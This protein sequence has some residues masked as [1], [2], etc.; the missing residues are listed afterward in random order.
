MF[1]ASSKYPENCFLFISTWRL[2][3]LCIRQI[4][5]PSFKKFIKIIKSSTYF[6][7]IK[8]V[9]TS[10]SRKARWVVY[11]IICTAHGIILPWR[12]MTSLIAW[13]LE[14]RGI[15]GLRTETKWNNKVFRTS[16]VLKL[17]WNKSKNRFFFNISIQYLV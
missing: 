3:G 17:Q 15:V 6:C 1:R 12:T 13:I 8:L 14:F 5:K 7:A 4:W 9:S 16:L 11:D 10:A 2:Q